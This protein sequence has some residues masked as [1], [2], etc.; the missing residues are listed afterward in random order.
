M[1]VMVPESSRKEMSVLED[2]AWDWKVE[3]L[4]HKGGW[5]LLAEHLL[6]LGDY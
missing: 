1:L 5:P 4:Q 6:N 2:E 3:A